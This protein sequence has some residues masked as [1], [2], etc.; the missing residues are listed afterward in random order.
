MVLEFLEL[1]LLICPELFVNEVPCVY[2]CKKAEIFLI[3]QD[4]QS[5]LVLFFSWDLFVKVSSSRVY[6]RRAPLYPKK[7]EVAAM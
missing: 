2:Y 1:F 5:F 7:E 4:G 3:R 6:I